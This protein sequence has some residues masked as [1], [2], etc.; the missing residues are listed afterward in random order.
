MSSPDTNALGSISSRKFEIEEDK[1]Q[2]QF[3]PPPGLVVLPKKDDNLICPAL[4][5]SII[6]APLQIRSEKATPIYSE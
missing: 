6:A 4:F 3:E 1:S 5:D 2:F